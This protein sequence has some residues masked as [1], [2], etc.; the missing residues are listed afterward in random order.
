MKEN[1]NSWISLHQFTVLVIMFGVGSSILVA[2]ASLAAAAK[3]DAWISSFIGVVVGFL[4]IIVYIALANLFPRQTLI[5]I[6]ESVFGKWLG[7]L[8]SFLYVQFFFILSFMLLGDIGY[9]LTTEVMPETPIIFI[10]GGVM[11]IVVMATRLGPVVFAEGAEIFFP[12]VMFMIV[13]TVVML[14][15]NIESRKI[16]PI[17][18]NGFMP[19][20]KASVPFV[21]LQEYVILLMIYPLVKNAKRAGKAFYSGS[22]IAGLLLVITILIC[23]LVLGSSLTQVSMYPTFT[24]AKKISIGNFLE[25][26]EVIVG[27]LWFVTIIF[28]LILTFFAAS[29]G[30]SQLF[31]FKSYRFLTI[32][33]GM[34]TT[35]FVLPAY[36]NIVFVMDFIHRVWPAYGLTFMV[37]LPFL[38]LLAALLLKKKKKQEQ[39]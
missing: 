24:L 6:N 36:T 37:A 26:V 34:L 22:L 12:W 32:P 25:R 14:L 27:G 16:E 19:V 2:P 29:H 21:S 28:K 23:I 20:L 30:I 7:K 38:T 10:M 5:E 33:L 4:P 35:V 8:I 18:E 9:F 17:L 31:G 13:M 3:Q 11:F 1:N 15:P 39:A